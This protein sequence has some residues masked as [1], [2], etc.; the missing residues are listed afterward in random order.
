MDGTF[1]EV[2]IDDRL[3]VVKAKAGFKSAFSQSRGGKEM[4]VMLLEKAWAK[5]NGSYENTITGLPAD[6]LRALTGA[7][8]D[9]YAHDYTTDEDLWKVVIEGHRSN[10]IICGSSATD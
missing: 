1:T 4:W 10:H 8:V 5:V 7:P 9:F 2:L 3:P 6:A